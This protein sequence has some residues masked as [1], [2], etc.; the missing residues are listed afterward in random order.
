MPKKTRKQKERSTKR[1]QEQT[2][3]QSHVKREFE[4]NFKTSDL[5]FPKKTDF[6]KVDNSFYSYDTSFI[7]RD[8]TRT[9]LLACGILVLEVMIYLA[10]FK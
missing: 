7:I 4:F 10:W 1:R 9:L 6:K 3:S 5:N 2:Q 8:L